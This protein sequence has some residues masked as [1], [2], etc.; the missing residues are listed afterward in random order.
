[1]PG[2]AAMGGAGPEWT[3]VLRSRGSFHGKKV[4][5]RPDGLSGDGSEFDT[6]AIGER[7]HEDQAAPRYGFRGRELVPGEVAAPGVRHFDAERLGGG[8]EGKS[9]VPSGEPAVRGGVCGELGD[10]VFGG[11]DDAGWQA[12]GAQPLR[13]QEAGEVGAAWRGGQQDAE[14]PGRGEGLGGVSLVHVTERG[15]VCVP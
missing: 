2:V 1:M 12:P 6:P 7:V 15:G 8:V 10:E 11:A 3:A 9:E 5:F 14:V 4:E 13:G